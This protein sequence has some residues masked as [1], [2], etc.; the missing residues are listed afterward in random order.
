[1]TIDAGDV[2][3]INNFVA[4][5]RPLQIPQPPGF[6]IS[7]P[8][9][10]DP[11]LSLNRTDES[12]GSS[13]SSFILPP[14]SYNLTVNLDNPSPAGSAGLDEAILTLAYD[15]SALS[16]S[17]QDITLGTIPVQATGWQ[18]SSVVDA[19]TGQIAIELYSSAPITAT[20]GG[21]LVNIAFHVTAA[22]KL[23]VNAQGT[24]LVQLV[25]SATI[26]G[27]SFSTMAADPLGRMVLDIG[28][29]SVNVPLPVL[30]LPITPLSAATALPNRLRT[31][32]TDV[33][34]EVRPIVATEL[35][36]AL[37]TLVAHEPGRLIPDEFLIPPPLATAIEGTTSFI[38]SFQLGIPVQLNTL[39]LQ[40][41]SLDQNL[42]KLLPALTRWAESQ[43]DV[44]QWSKL[45]TD[46]LRAETE[47]PSVLADAP[48]GSPEAD[49][50][51]L[52]ERIFAGMANDTDDF[53]DL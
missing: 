37:V 28:A 30:D 13:D 3:A 4:V 38:S 18:I 44:G 26:N 6:A 10:A 23:G 21:S 27:Q 53:G 8:N 2:S 39:L 14:S 51:V 40:N 32:F 45:L 43:L 31:G 1:L 36:E 52:L 11:M 12:A 41:S 48:A 9:Q 46:L 35:T 16:V 17:A 15:P 20:T 5:L 7:S 19:T 33:A 25:D 49:P 34:D 42:P 50:R 22:G 29:N 47:P 24:T